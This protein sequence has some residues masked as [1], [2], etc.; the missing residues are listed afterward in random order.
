MVVTCPLILVHGFDPMS[1]NYILILDILT[2]RAPLRKNDFGYRMG[3]KV[4]HEPIN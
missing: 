4:Q 1:I 2:H 3:A